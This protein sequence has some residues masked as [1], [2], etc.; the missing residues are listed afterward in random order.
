[1]ITT[2][3]DQKRKI[4]LNIV[5][6]Q[7]LRKSTNALKRLKMQTM[8]LIRIDKV[9]DIDNASNTKTVSDKGKKIDYVKS[10]KRNLKAN[11]NTRESI[12]QSL[13]ELISQFS[14]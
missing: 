1:M 5:K 8:S 4:I 2:V 6:K 14:N 10:L 9:S 12:I 11:V 7:Q 3:K 13:K